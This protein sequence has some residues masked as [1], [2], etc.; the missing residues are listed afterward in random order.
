MVR[1]GSYKV[2]QEGIEPPTLALGVPCS[3]HLSYWGIAAMRVRVHSTMQGLAT[4]E[5]K[6]GCCR[7]SRAAG[8]FGQHLDDSTGLVLRPFDFA[9]GSGLRPWNDM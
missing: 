9:Q 5:T 8:F 7:A 2:P 6:N 3:I 4:S 1:V